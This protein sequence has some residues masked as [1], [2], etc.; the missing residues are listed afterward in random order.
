[1]SN[2]WYYADRAGQQ[3]GPVAAD[4]LSAALQRGELSAASLVWREGMADWQPLSS[5]MAELGAQSPPPVPGPAVA[6]AAAAATPRVVAGGKPVVVAPRSG[7]STVLIVVI[8]VFGVLLVGGSILAAIAIPAYNDYTQRAKLATVVNEASTLRLQVAEAK[9]GEQRCLYNGEDGIGEA[10]SYA[11]QH[12]QAIVVGELEG[13]ADTC[14]IQITLR[15]ISLSSV[16]D[17]AVLLMKLQPDGGWRYESD[18]PP[19]YLP[20]SIRDKLD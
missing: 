20:A 17:G 12:V 9:L 7:S 18:V 13:D 11:G 14:A 4:W 16:P 5:V 15:N 19:R 6:A 8:V 10:E 2:I 1:M 3:Q